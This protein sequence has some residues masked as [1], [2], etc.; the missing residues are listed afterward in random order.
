MNNIP[1]TATKEVYNKNTSMSV[2][3]R[4]NKATMRNVILYVTDVITLGRHGAEQL[5]KEKRNI[6]VKIL[7][8]KRG[9]ER[10]ERW[11]RNEL[12]QNIRTILDKIRLK[13]HLLDMWSGRIWT[14]GPKEVGRQ[15]GRW[16]KKWKQSRLL[17]SGTTGLKWG[18]V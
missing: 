16:E 7:G 3:I 17:K 6:F 4:H 18:S 2:K 15:Q 12:Y 9:S 13:G 8:Q 11:S 10:W 14:E 5:Q 1:Y